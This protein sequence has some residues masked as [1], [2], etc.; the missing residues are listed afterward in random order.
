MKMHDNFVISDPL[1]FSLG[2][3]SDGTLFY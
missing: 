2:I 1:R 3:I